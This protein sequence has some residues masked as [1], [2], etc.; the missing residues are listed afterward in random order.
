[1]TGQVGFEIIPYVFGKDLPDKLENVRFAQKF[2]PIVYL[3]SNADSKLAYVGETS[4]VVARMIAHFRSETKSTLTDAQLIYS[5]IFNKSATLDIEANLIKYLDGDGKYKL[6]NANLGLSNHNYY[7]KHD[8]YQGMFKAIWAELQRLK[9]AGRTLEQIDNLDEF[10]YSPFK[11]LSTEQRKGVKAILC[12]LLDNTHRFTLIEGGA[13]SGKT[14]MAVYLF[15]LLRTPLE[16]F[17]LQH[18]QGEE[19]EIA[20]LVMRFRAQYPEPKMALVVSMSSFRGTLK[21]IFRHV[22]DLH[23]DMV[24]GPAELAG[25]SY[26]LLLADEAHRLRQRVN[27]GSYFKALDD[28]ATARGFDKHT[29]SEVDWVKLRGR[30]AVFFYDQYQSI[31]PSDADEEV[32]DDLRTYEQ[33]NVVD[34]FTQFR[35][36][37]GKKYVKFLH[38]L[39]YEGMKPNRKPYVSRRYEL[40][41][42]SDLPDMYTAIQEKENRHGLARIVAGYAWPWRSK[43]DKEAYD[44]FL[45]GMQLRWNGTSIDWVNSP[46]AVKEVG[47]IHTTQGYDLN[48]TGIIFGPEIGY[49]PVAREIVIHREHYHDKNGKNTIKDP[50]RL[51]RY[52]LNIY[53]TLMLRGIRG[54]YLY[55]CDDAL[56]EYFAQYIPLAE[57]DD[58]PA[59]SLTGQESTISLIPFQNS[60]PLYSLTAAAGS[61]SEQQQVSDDE[62]EFIHVPEGI[63]ITTDH[64]ACR[65]VGESMNR[66]IPNDSICLFRKYNSG[67]RNGLIVLAQHTDRQDADFGS[68]YTVKEYQ[69]TKYHD[70]HGWHHQTIM[71]I[72]DSDDPAYKTL[73]LQDDQLNSFSVIGIFEQVL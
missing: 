52:I 4:D 70:E 49:D 6:L 55:V 1:M 29:C 73:H 17:E 51:K 47:C 30:K 31:R 56:R 64:F 34:L 9:I 8:V 46:N 5:D 63:R 7:Q 66:V 42:F 71:L 41:L 69:S 25:R 60:V 22:K 18:L 14:V 62:K 58:A 19:Y 61:F 3:L 67:S 45:D 72:P 23:Q 43:K 27:L 44:I 53:R 12:S 59:A 13:G 36:R 68:Q 48:Y 15:K 20:E 37:G 57:G 2:W 21:K 16:D 26:D 11:T 24:I 33:T 54:T 40:K 28:A 32:F 35:V 50:K 10:K 38:E 39:L 65:V